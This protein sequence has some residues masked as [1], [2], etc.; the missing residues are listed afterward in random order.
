M[1][2]VCAYWTRHGVCLQP[3]I[4]EKRHTFALDNSVI[5]APAFNPNAKKADDDDDKIYRELQEAII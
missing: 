5:N 3:A 1:A 2:E 4:C